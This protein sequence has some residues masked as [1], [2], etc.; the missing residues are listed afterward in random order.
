MAQLRLEAALDP[1][2]ALDFSPEGK[3]VIA[4][5]PNGD[6]GVWWA[7]TGDELDFVSLESSDW[8]DARM[9]TARS[10]LAVSNQGE[11]SVVYLD[12]HWTL[13]H[14]LGEENGFADRVNVLAFSQDGEWLAA[15]GGDLSRTGEI[16]VWELKTLELVKDFPRGSQ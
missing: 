11:A 4:L 9:L 13:K 15:S 3:R 12:Q 8:I 5:G 16:K 7:A 6:V 1:L 10:V 2:L 14:I